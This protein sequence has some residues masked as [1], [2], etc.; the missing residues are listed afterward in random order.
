[1]QMQMTAVMGIH[2]V[3]VV[4]RYRDSVD[5]CHIEITLHS[6]LLLYLCYFMPILTFLYIKEMFISKMFVTQ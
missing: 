1:M 5:C 6:Y 3:I 4:N 2:V